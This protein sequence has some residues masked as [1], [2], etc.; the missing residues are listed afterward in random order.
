MKLTYL[1]LFYFFALLLPVVA[2]AMPLD[3]GNEALAAGDFQKAVEFY[4]ETLDGDGPNV[5]ALY[6]VGNAHYRLG[7]YGPAILSYER[8][9]LIDP[10]APDIRANL[11]MA[12]D[13]AASFDDNAGAAWRAPLYWL[14]FDEWLCLGAAALSLLALASIAGGFILPKPKTRPLAWLGIISTVALFFSIA[15]V[16]LRHSELDRAIVLRPNTEVR[17]SP[18]AT[19]EI[20]ATLQAGRPVQ[21][22]REHDGFYLIA[23]GW[24]SHEDAELVFPDR[25]FNIEQG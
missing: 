3:E 14:S 12:R 5:A 19:A 18:F 23:N 9:L 25:K 13:A 16:S 22:E 24:I 21:V 7:A 15:A 1:T 20:V 2:T 8:A 6:N 10:R 11:K 4:T 17:L